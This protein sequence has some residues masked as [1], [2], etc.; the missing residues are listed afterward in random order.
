MITYRYE[1]YG[2]ALVPENDSN[3][4]S[5]PLHFPLFSKTGCYAR[6]F[7]AEFLQPHLFL[8]MS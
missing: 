1:I 8:L 7:L 5:F 4:E 2:Y 6:L 3:E